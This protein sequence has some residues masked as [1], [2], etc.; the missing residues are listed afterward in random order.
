MNITIAEN[1]YT[2]EGWLN[3]PN[4]YLTFVGNVKLDEQGR[5]EPGTWT[6]SDAMPATENTLVA[7]NSVNFMGGSFPGY[8]HLLHCNTSDDIEVGLVK[9]GTVTVDRKSDGQYSFSYDFTTATGNKITGHY[10]GNIDVQNLP[11]ADNTLLT[12]DYTL[13]LSDAQ[14]LF[15]NNG[16]HVHID[17]FNENSRYRMINDRMNLIL[18]LK[19][20]FKP[21]IYKVTDDGNC[22]G[23]IEPGY[24]DIDWA[25]GSIMFKFR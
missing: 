16:E 12:E 4:N 21:G 20:D 9:S 1:G 23:T 14:I 22:A 19:D 3:V 7:G 6:V 5:I 8:T 17:N 10:E 11:V 2:D 18:N 13:D 15:V 24:F 25:T